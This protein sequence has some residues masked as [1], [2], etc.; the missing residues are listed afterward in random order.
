MFAASET[1]VNKEE[2]PTRQNILK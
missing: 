1:E 2:Q